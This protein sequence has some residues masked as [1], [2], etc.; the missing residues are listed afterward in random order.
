MSAAP[1]I[2]LSD[3]VLGQFVWG[4]WEISPAWKSNAVPTPNI[5]MGVCSQGRPLVGVSRLEPALRLKKQ[6]YLLLD[7]LR[8]QR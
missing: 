5:A 2:E 1:G 6:D 8:S 4:A 7:W 3:Q